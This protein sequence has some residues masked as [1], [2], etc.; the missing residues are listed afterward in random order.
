MQR[1]LGF[2]AGLLLWM[3]LAVSAQPGAGISGVITDL[4]EKPLADAVVALK[5]VDFG[6]TYTTKTDKNGF[7]RQMG[8]RPGAYELTVKIPGQEV[9]VVTDKVTLASTPDNHYDIDLKKRV[10]LPSAEQLEAQKKQEEAAKKFESMKAAY[11]DGQAKVDE[12]DK[13]R[14]EMKKAP[15]DQ[16]SALQTK[17]TGLYQD[18]LHSFQAAQ[19]AAPEKDPNMH[20]LYYKL[21]YANEMLGKYDEAVA[22]YQKAVDLKPL[23]DYYNTMSLALAKANKTPDA[24]QAC[25]K[26]SAA[27]AAK[28]GTCWLNL[29]VILYNANRLAEA[30]E[31]L[32]K[33][34][35]V[36]PNNADA[37]YLLGASL[38]STMQTKQQ[39]D[40]ITYIVTP[41]TVEAYQKYLQ[42]APTGRFAGEAQA[43]LQALQSLGAGVETK[44]KVK[45][46]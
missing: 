5:S 23:P 16:R 15:A 13:A 28:G 18:A 42:L 24:M 4:Q 17:A 44:V 38:L 14:D 37:W 7:Y 20:L 3:G 6:V 45:K 46:P 30:V 12:A 26:S 11:L 9:P 1:K 31:P 36:N 29:G 39:G 35:S 27:D 41:G 2:L 10:I 34:T 19:Q 8:L 21:G 43:S 33:A 40:K 25:E 32:K 22:D